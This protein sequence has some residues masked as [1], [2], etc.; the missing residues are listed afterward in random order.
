VIRELDR[1]QRDGIDVR[2]LWDSRTDQVSVAV[3]D[4]QSGEMFMLPIDGAY[5]R[6]AFA[7]PFAY[8]SLGPA[9]IAA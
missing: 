4:E 7:H 8:A 1:R 9:I 2:L 5:A 6:E 3:E